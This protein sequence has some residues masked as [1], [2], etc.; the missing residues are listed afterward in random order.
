M[1]AGVSRNFIPTAC[2]DRG[3][4][5]PVTAAGRGTMCTGQGPERETKGL[6][7]ERRGA[8]RYSL[9]TAARRHRFSLGAVAP[10][11]VDIIPSNDIMN[12]QRLRRTA[13]Y[14]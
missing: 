6:S 8:E 10:P 11:G 5:L 3:P 9:C 1:H 2:Q 13:R 14:P 12:S 4:E 7:R